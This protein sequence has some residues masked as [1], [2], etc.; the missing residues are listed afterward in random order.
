MASGL[1]REHQ[2]RCVVI[3]EALTIFIR[4]ALLGMTGLDIADPGLEFFLRNLNVAN[5]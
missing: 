2:H 4:G 1:L 5:F 3:A